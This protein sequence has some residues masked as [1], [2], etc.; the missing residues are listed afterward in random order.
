MP[1]QP[2][3]DGLFR[4]LDH[5]VCAKAGNLLRIGDEPATERASP[6]RCVY[7]VFATEGCANFC[8]PQHADKRQLARERPQL[9]AGACCPIDRRK[10][11]GRLPCPGRVGHPLKAAD[12]KAGPSCETDRIDTALRQKSLDAIRNVGGHHNRPARGARKQPL[13]DRAFHYIPARRQPQT[14]S[15]QPCSDVGH[16]LATRTDDKAQQAE[17]VA[18]LSGYNAAPLGAVATGLRLAP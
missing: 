16:K 7:H 1:R 15:G 4:P 5:R 14:P 3:W 2:A 17:P 8:C 13:G 12:R 9:A 18:D 10:Q 6:E 11:Q